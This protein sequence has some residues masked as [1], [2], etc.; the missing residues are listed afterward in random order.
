MQ[1]P[2]EQLLDPFRRAGVTAHFLTFYSFLRD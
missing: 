2:I 1:I